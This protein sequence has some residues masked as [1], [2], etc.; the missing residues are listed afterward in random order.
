MDKFGE[1]LKDGDNVFEY[2]YDSCY[3]IQEYM[4]R[5]ME[6]LIIQMIIEAHESGQDSIPMDQI[7]KKNHWDTDQI[8]SE[9][10]DNYDEHWSIETLILDTTVFIIGDLRLGRVDSIELT[11]FTEAIDRVA[12]NA[13]KAGYQLGKRNDEGNSEL[14]E[15][16]MRFSGM[17]SNLI[18]LNSR[19]VQQRQ[20]A[21]SASNVNSYR[22]RMDDAEIISES[23]DN[24]EH[25]PLVIL[26]MEV[27]D[28]IE[29]NFTIN[30]NTLAKVKDQINES[31][32]EFATVG[33]SHQGTASEREI[34]FSKQ[35]EN[36]ANYLNTLPT[37][38]DTVNLPFSVLYNPDFEAVKILSYLK[39]TGSLR[40]KWN[41][42]RHWQV[43]FK[44]TPISVESLLGKSEYIKEPKPNDYQI[45]YNLSFT[46]EPCSLTLTSTEGTATKIPVI[47][48]V[49]KEVLRLIFKNSNR[50]HDEW[51]LYDISE[52]L[53]SEDV[54][55]K[56]VA[57]AIYQFNLK[58][59]RSLPHVKRLFE[60][61]YSSARLNP[62]YV[63]QS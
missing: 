25:S 41:Q 11:N 63:L 18:T 31:L 1:T 54:N 46:A 10:Y 42:S 20:E 51:S 4:N 43:S 48:Q 38:A 50:S 6:F 8:T 36:F 61:N 57:N 14:R 62:K 34:D 47:G 5:D 19:Y 9:V 45:K 26:V 23:M 7:I 56:A 58:V 33:K 29:V 44:Q 16:S 59:Q 21:F 30:Q 28:L 35:I 37:I 12:E 39:E 32:E 52:I 55:P 15:S 49:Q 17:I 13:V 22:I 24:Y 27:P 60:Y 2:E 3:T 40:F 53:G